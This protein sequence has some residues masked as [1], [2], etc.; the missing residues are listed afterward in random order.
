MEVATGQYRVHDGSDGCSS[1][2]STRGAL[3]GD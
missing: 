1:L 2:F 3:V